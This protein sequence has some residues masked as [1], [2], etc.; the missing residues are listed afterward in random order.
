VTE[1]NEL[2]SLTQNSDINIITHEITS[3]IVIWPSDLINRTHKC[4]VN[5]KIP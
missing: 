4:D 5:I 2:N 1:T 3:G